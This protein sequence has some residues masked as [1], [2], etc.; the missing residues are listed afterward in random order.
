VPG[1]DGAAAAAGRERLRRLGEKP[2]V[3][4][5]RERL[6][7]LGEGPA[8]AVVGAVGAARDGV[9]ET[10]SEQMPVARV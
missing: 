2:A 7:G 6:R 10:A 1:A 8:A 9:S 5:G 4:V 3:A